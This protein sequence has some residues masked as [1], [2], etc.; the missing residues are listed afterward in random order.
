[1]DLRGLPKNIIVVDDD[2]QRSLQFAHL[3]K[4]FGYNV[5]VAATC[6]GLTGFAGKFIPHVALLDIRIKNDKGK[7]C[8][9]Y[10]REAH[11]PGEMKLLTIGGWGDKKLL[12]DSLYKGADGYFVRPVMPTPLICKL[13]SLTETVPRSVPR[14]DII[15]RIT[16]DNEGDKKVYYAT[17][18]SEKGVFVATA[19]PLPARSK[20]VLVMDLPGM[21]SVEIGGEVIYNLV[22]G[23]ARLQSPGMGIRFENISEKLQEGLRHFV[24]GRFLEEPPESVL[25]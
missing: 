3:L 24:E 17:M 23:V 10:I 19:E 14:L 9:D 5:F 15:F 7:P 21:R 11:L 13:E 6:H 4:R 16:V 2:R 1:M 20:V 12:E 8:I 22:K 25:I 18:L